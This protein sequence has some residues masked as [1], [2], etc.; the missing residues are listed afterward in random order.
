MHYYYNKK[1]VNMTEHIYQLDSYLKEY[2][3]IIVSIKDNSVILDKT[4]FHP[5]AGGLESDTG[6]LEVNG[7]RYK[8]LNVLQEKDSEDVLHQLD[9]VDGL[10]PGDRVHLA[11]DWERRYKMMKLHTA[12]HIIAAIIYN[13][14]NALI[15]G[16]NITPEYAY[17]DYSLESSDRSIFDKVVQKANE[18]VKKNIELKIYWLD[19]EEAMKIPGIVKLAAR[20]PPNVKKLRIVEIPGVD[21]QADGGPHVKNTGEIGEIVITKIENKGKNR[22]RMYYT[23]K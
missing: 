2:D 4:I 20:M 16:G 23:L 18:V 17:D 9:T 3:S 21:I 5:R 8:V 11:L 6:F 22:K 1:V 19:R 13:D 7:R 15:T 12:S 10:N 14:Y